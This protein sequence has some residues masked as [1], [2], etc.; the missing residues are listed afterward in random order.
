VHGVRATGNTFQVVRAAAGVCNVNFISANCTSLN[1]NT[2][3]P[4]MTILLT[5]DASN[6][7]AC[8]PVI[9]IG[10]QNA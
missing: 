6:W 5:L 8:S 4:D 9:H 7:G 10:P 1:I 3:I 2:G